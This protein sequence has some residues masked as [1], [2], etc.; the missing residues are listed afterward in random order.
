VG[1]FGIMKKM[2]NE[3]GQEH[4]VTHE[5]APASLWSMRRKFLYFL[6]F[7][8]VIILLSIYPIYKTFFSAAPTCFDGKQNQ[9][10]VGVDCGG[11]CTLVCSQQVTPVNIIW[12]NFF[13]VQ[14]G[15]YDI[16]ALIEN[17][18]TGAGVKHLAYT[19]R[20]FDGSN[21]L[22]AER[23]GVS[24][25]NPNERTL[26]FEPNV[27]VLNQVPARVEV[28][29][30]TPEWTVAKDT[31]PS[32]VVKN[33]VLSNT[34]TE[35]RLTVTLENDDNTPL[36]NIEARALVYDAQRNIIAV[37]STF[38]DG[39]IPGE[40]R[41]VFFTWPNPISGIG[42]QHA[43]TAPVDAML[44]FDRSGSMN[45]DNT[46]PPE[47]ITT[48]KNAAQAFVDNMQARDDI[49]LVSF[50]TNASLDQALTSDRTR[51]KSAINAITIGTPDNEQQTNIGDGARAAINELVS[52]HTRAD[53][54]KAL[55]LLTDGI[56]SRPL[57]PNDPK[58]EQYPETYAEQQIA[59]AK[60]DNILVYVIGLGAKVNQSFLQSIATTPAYYYGAATASDLA[61]IYR[62]IAASVCT[63]EAFITE[64][65][66][67][68]DGFTSVQ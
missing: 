28:D 1:V 32:L 2:E 47:P 21:Q 4:E 62:E 66:V 24:F 36:Q 25:L 50:A 5:E 45:D 54:K 20:L 3:F 43:C 55:V 64:I 10:E 31:K 58:D 60:A 63:D 8:G 11:P 17:Q 9:G 57:N 26:L 35:P 68:T 53:A 29:L 40:S 39:L 13:K 41:T 46:D 49:G 23:S 37:S 6:L 48:A 33:K 15:I 19:L 34:D 12:G 52:G 38:V 67:R 22:I 61:Q 44:V 56:A 7:V 16:A 51:L 14:D 65:L 18:N 42:Y 59:Q 30:G 27:E